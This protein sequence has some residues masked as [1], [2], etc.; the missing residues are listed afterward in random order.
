MNR[1]ALKEILNETSEILEFIREE[2]RRPS[3]CQRTFANWKK[4]G[5]P[6]HK[7]RNGRLFMLKSEFRRWYYKQ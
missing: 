4:R 6:L 1:L 3:F 7:T 5:L 2:T